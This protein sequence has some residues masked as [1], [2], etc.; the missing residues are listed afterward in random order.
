M[1]FYFV[2]IQNL[3]VKLTAVMLCVFMMSG[4]IR[5]PALATEAD[6]AYPLVDA[7][8][9]RTAK[10]A[11]G[12]EKLQE[13]VDLI[14]GSIEPQAVNLLIERFPASG[15]RRQMTPLAGRS[16]CISITGTGIR[17]AS[18]SMSTSLPA[19]MPMSMAIRCMKMAKPGSNT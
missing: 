6:E 17:T 5:V 13:L 18:R 14:V 12:Y 1:K 9:S 4:F 10:D 7:Y 3:F 2:E 15:K 8:C 16:A 11:L 19:P